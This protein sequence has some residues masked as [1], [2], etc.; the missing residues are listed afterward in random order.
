MTENLNFW[1]WYFKYNNGRVFANAEYAWFNQDIHRL[2]PGPTA[3]N[4]FVALPT[5]V[6]GNMFFAEGG[7]MAGPSKLTFMFGRS[8]GPVLN[9]PN[10]T[11]SYQS[12]PIAYQATDPYN[13]LMFS[14]YGGG[15]QTFGGLFQAEDGHG[16]MS[17][18]FCYAAR[19]DYAVAS[20]LNVWATCMWAHRLEKFGFNFG[21]VN[22]AGAT[23][24]ALSAD[25]IAFAA[26]AGRAAATRFVGGGAG[27]TT[28]YGWV[29]GRFRRLGGQC[30][31]GLETPRR[32]NLA[33]QIRLLATRR[34]FPR[35]LAGPTAQ[36]CR[37]SRRQPG[38]KQPGC[39]PG[40]KT[41]R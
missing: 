25:Q 9:N 34:F 32:R 18:A 26:N 31:R 39:H 14:T 3:P 17:D 19:L 11:K 23:A 28:T 38:S 5:N 37:Y 8:S 21:G 41:H 40:R 15:N 6:E 10:P 24:A 20:N 27:T 1:M 7:F 36:C 29:S 4:I 13:W 16:A 2:G 12:I 35:S 30:R 33:K 22:S